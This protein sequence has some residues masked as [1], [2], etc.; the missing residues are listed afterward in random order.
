MNLPKLPSS[1]NLKIGARVTAAGGLG[2][3][4]GNLLIWWM[5]KGLALPMNDT[6]N[7]AILG[8]CAIAAGWALKD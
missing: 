8:I 5:D 2:I 7:G 4:I 1:D 3:H 6:V